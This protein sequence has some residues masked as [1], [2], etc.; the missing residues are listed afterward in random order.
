MDRSIKVCDTDGIKLQELR[1][2]NLKV[3][4]IASDS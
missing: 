3:K 2:E 1:P 4:I